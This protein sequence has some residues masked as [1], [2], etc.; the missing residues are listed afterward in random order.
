MR[1]FLPIIM[2]LS[3][4]LGAELLKNTSFEEVNERKF[5]HWTTNHFNTGGKHD[6]GTMD[7]HTGQHYA[8]CRS[9]TDQERSVG[10]TSTTTARYRRRNCFR[11]VSLH[12]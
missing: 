2:L 9:Y 7:A 10:P 8:I 1:H 4:P 3:L 11:M 12:A 6:I 5:A